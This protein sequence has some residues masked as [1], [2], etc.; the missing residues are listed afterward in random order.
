[1]RARTVVPAVVLLL[2]AA[3]A[4]P[5]PAADAARHKGHG[6]YDVYRHFH[7]PCGGN[8]ATGKPDRCS[9][10]LRWG[11]R[12]FGYRHIKLRHGYNRRTEAMIR[13][14]LRRGVSKCYPPPGDL[15]CTTEV[16][17]LTSGDFFDRVVVSHRIVRHREVGIITA[18][19][20]GNFGGGDF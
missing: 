12:K 8:F 4:M 7:Y 5:W 10:A 9:V 17:T 13:R 16:F 15:P 2:C 18:Y 6:T 14:V 19:S 1:M 20:G 3:A 11:N